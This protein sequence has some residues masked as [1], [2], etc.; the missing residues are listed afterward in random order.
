MSALCQRVH[1]RSAHAISLNPTRLLYSSQCIEN[2]QYSEN[3]AIPKESRSLGG[4]GLRLF[5]RFVTPVF[6]SNNA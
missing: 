5:G 3:G 4:S 6:G 1:Q 2:R